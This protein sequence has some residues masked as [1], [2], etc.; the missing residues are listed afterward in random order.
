M[1]RYNLTDVLYPSSDGIGRQ[2]HFQL[3]LPPTV[4]TQIEDVIA[5]RFPIGYRFSDFVRYAIHEQLR[6]ESIDPGLT[7]PAA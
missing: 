6:H 3:K 2:A 7:P 1:N 4:V 5:N